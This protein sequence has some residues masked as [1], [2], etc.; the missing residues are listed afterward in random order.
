VVF[1]GESRI[2]RPPLSL[3]AACFIGALALSRLLGAATATEPGAQPAALDAW[4]LQ[5]RYLLVG[6]A[7]A[8]L[9]RAMYP[10]HAPRS[11][12][13]FVTVVGVQD[14]RAGQVAS[15]TFFCHFPVMMLIAAASSAL[16]D[17][18]LMRRP[19]AAAY[20]AFTLLAGAC[21]AVTVAVAR[22]VAGTRHELGHRPWPM[23]RSR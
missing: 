18:P 4:L 17:Q 15:F 10:E 19:T 11:A 8:A 20:G 6:A 2:L 12:S 3:A 9:A 1:L 14:G 16:L 13:P 23:R 22:A 7:F 5:N 21:L